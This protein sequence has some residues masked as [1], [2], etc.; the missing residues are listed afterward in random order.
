MTW[1]RAE[2]CRRGPGREVG[3]KSE[4]FILNRPLS[5]CHGWVYEE[6]R[7]DI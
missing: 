3:V 7:A 2:E 5:Y 4:G 1:S 6:P